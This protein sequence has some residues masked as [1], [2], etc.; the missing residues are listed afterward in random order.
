MEMIA[1]LDLLV[2]P[3]VLTAKSIFVL[4]DSSALL[5]QQLLQLAL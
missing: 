3:K 5:D 2:L 1:P 4:K